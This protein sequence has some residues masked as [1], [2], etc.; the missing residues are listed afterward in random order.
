MLGKNNM[1]SNFQC[2]H[3]QIMYKFLNVNYCNGTSS[4][5]PCNKTIFRYVEFLKFIKWLT[6]N[7]SYNFFQNIKSKSNKRSSLSQNES[8]KIYILV[9]EWEHRV[10]GKPQNLRDGLTQH[11]RIVLH[12]QLKTQ[13]PWPRQ[14]TFV[15]AVDNILGVCR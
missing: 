6:I 4:L 11:R 15:L 5:I 1:L 14:R 8:K 9:S 12:L 7:Y 3:K 2:L 10:R 13:V